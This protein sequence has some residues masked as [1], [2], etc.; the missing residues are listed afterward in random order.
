MSDD[1]LLIFRASAAGSCSRKIAQMILDPEST[2]PDPSRQRFLTGGHYHQAQITRELREAGIEIQAVEAEGILRGLDGIKIV[3]HIDGFLPEY[4]ELLEVKA[5]TDSRFSQLSDSDDWREVYPN[6]VPPAQ[7]YGH[8][9]RWIHTVESLE[10]APQDQFEN[11]EPGDDVIV[12]DGVPLGELAPLATRYIF[13]NRDSSL[14]LGGLELDI[15]SYVYRPDMRL[16]PDGDLLGETIAKYTKAAEAV[17]K[18]EAP[19][20]CDAVGWCFFCQQ[21]GGRSPSGPKKGR[22][23]YTDPDDRDGDEELTEMAA[24]AQEYVAVKE[25]AKQDKSRIS[26]LRGELVSMMKELDPKAEEFDFELDD[27]SVVV[28]KRSQMRRTYPDRDTLNELMEKGMLPKVGSESDQLRY[29]TR[30]S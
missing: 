13:I 15:P 2:E 25:R 30:E 3:G 11:A 12:L 1:N 27:G 20:E 8:M 10:M 29:D 26:S 21:W 18:G 28:L 9:D 23:V 24:M 17:R 7:V 22:V 16:E 5:I 4:G 6:Y 19:R 14:A